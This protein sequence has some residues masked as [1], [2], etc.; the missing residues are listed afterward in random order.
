LWLDPLPQERIEVY[1]EYI[2]K[3]AA[4]AAEDPEAAA[5]LAQFQLI[6]RNSTSRH[7]TKATKAWETKQVDGS[8]SMAEAQLD[9]V[10]AG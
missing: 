1:N 3:L 10:I 5:M 4:R 6:L 2:P 9:W 8:P 7:Q